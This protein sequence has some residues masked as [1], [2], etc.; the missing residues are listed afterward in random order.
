MEIIGELEPDPRGVYTGCVGYLAP[1][2]KASFNVAIRSVWIDRATGQAEYGVGG[3]IVWDSSDAGEYAECRTKAAVLTAEI[4][5]FELLETLLWDGRDGYFLLE[6]HLRRL[7]DSAEYFAFALDREAVRRRLDEFGAALPDGRHRVRLCVN[8][9]GEA[10]IESASLALAQEP[11]VYRLRIADRPMDRRNPFLYHKT[12]HRSFYPAARPA[13]GECDD[14]VL[15]NEQGQATE[16]TIANLVVQQGGRLIT[17]PVESGLLPGVFRRHLL[18]TGQIV[19]GVVTLDDLRRAERV[20]AVNSVRKWMPATMLWKEIAQ[21]CARESP[22]PSRVIVGGHSS[23]Q[24]ARSGRSSSF[25]A[26]ASL[27]IC[28][29]CGFHWIGRPRRMQRSLKW[30]IVSERMADSSGLIVGLRLLMQ[31]MKF[32]ACDVLW[33]RCFSPDLIFAVCNDLRLA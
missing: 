7:A 24:G 33:V 4:P 25:V 14:V 26:S 18:E 2:R 8:R 23:V 11:P 31:S 30:L 20:F 6:G 3:G 13:G 10:T 19:E 12:T 16:T 15:W 9:Q 17:P 22:N 29:F 5:R 27:T 32:R 21:S 1:G 28:S